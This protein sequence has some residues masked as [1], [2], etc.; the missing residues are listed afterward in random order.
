MLVC[1]VVYMYA[2]FRGVV[3]CCTVSLYNVRCYAVLCFVVLCCVLLYVVSMR[4]IS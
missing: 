3:W 4:C 1:D 2:V